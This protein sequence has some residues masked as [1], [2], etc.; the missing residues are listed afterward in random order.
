MNSACLPMIQ[1][2]VSNFGFF[3]YK[4]ACKLHIPYSWS[5]LVSAS[6]RA[7]RWG[8]LLRITNMAWYKWNFGVRCHFQNI[9]RRKFSI[10]HFLSIYDIY[11]MNKKY[12][13]QSRSLIVGTTMLWHYEIFWSNLP[14]HG[15][16][17]TVLTHVWAFMKTKMKMNS[18]NLGHA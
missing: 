13:C 2:T 18:D 11:D 17:K 14:W 6:V 16:S 3:I 4:Y 7:Y 15:R 8:Y 5:T 12:Q 9:G 10:N 1:L